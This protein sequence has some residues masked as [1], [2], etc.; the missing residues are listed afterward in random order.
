MPLANKIDQ[1]K[2][3][4]EL[5]EYRSKLRLMWDFRNDEQTFAADKFRLKCSF[6]LR[7]KRRY[8]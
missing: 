5:E 1:R 3:E 8:H 6:N 7:N 4:R 2:L